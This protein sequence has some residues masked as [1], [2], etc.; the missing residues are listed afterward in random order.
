MPR[1]SKKTMTKARKSSKQTKEATPAPVKEE[2]TVV[3]A[4][5]VEATPAEAAPVVVDPIDTMTAGFNEIMT[6]LSAMRTRITTLTSQLKALRTT[7]IKEYKTATKS[8]RRRAPK[9]P[10]RKPSGFVKPTLISN[11]LAK[12]LGKPSGTEMARTQVTREINAYIREHKLQDP[13]NGRRILADGKL[14]KLL[15]LKKDDELTYFNLQKYM[16]PHFTKQ[17]QASA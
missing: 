3:E 16:S 17:S 11:D 7:T 2:N 9:D 4:T 5:A 10:N 12:F 6:E 1:G 8:K 14:R 15:N 13:S